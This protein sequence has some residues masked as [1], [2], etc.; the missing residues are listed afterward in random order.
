[1]SDV[2]TI[3][4]SFV[5]SFAKEQCDTAISLL[6]VTLVLSV[7]PIGALIGSYIRTH[8][9]NKNEY[10]LKADGEDEMGLIGRKS[11]KKNSGSYVLKSFFATEEVDIPSVKLRKSGQSIPLKN[12]EDCEVLYQ[13]IFRHSIPHVQGLQAT[14]GGMD[15]AVYIINVF[16]QEV[17]YKVAAVTALEDSIAFYPRVENALMGCYATEADARAVIKNYPKTI[18]MHFSP[19]LVEKDKCYCSIDAVVGS[20]TVSRTW[21]KLSNG[22]LVEV[23]GGVPELEN[24]GLFHVTP[25]VEPEGYLLETFEFGCHN[26]SKRQ[27]FDMDGDEIECPFPD[28][29]QVY[30]YTIA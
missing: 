28:D 9:A 25:T 3:F 13:H 6:K 23:Q 5:G 20:K 29:D 14:Y 4:D 22:E 21:F 19:T 7:P 30:S 11:V 10:S 12:E 26:E 2:V 18:T 1:M 8:L 24:E 17:G 27:W 15:L 16:E